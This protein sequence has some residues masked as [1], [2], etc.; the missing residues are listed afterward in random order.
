M[1]NGHAHNTASQPRDRERER[2][3]G[4]NRDIMAL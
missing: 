4:E 1:F 3:S 2:A